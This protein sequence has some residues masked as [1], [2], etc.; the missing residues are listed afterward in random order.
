MGVIVSKDNE[1]NTELARRIDADLRSKATASKGAKNKATVD[2][3][4][5]AEYMKDLKK[6]GKFGWV[7]ILLVVGVILLLAALG[8]S[9]S[10]K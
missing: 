5:D 2:F 4:E 1:K 3:A 9:F 8:M 10:N 7:W 6:T